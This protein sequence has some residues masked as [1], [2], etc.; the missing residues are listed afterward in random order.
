MHYL[1]FSLSDLRDFVIVLAGSI[2]AAISLLVAV[3]LAVIFILARKGMKAAHRAVDVQVTG[4]LEKGLSISQQIR[5][6]TATLPGAPG[7][8][9]GAG[10]IVAAVRD[11]KQIEPPFRPRKKSWLPF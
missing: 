3:V 11:I 5:D 4:Y 2:Y 1:L 7:S 10:E 9:G 6:R 8:T